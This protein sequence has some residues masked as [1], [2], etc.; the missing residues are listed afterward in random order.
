MY[1]YKDEIIL[2]SD[3]SYKDT[4]KNAGKHWKTIFFGEKNDNKKMY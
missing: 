4:L 1:F 3:K 2:I